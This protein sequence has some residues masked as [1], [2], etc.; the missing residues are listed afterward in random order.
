MIATQQVRQLDF[1][2]ASGLV[3]HDGRFHAVADDENDLFVFGEQGPSQRITLLPG[4]LPTEP[5]RRKAEKPDFEILAALPGLG[6]LAMGSGSRPSRER[7]VLLD[8]HG[9]TTPIDTRPLCASLRQHFS[10]LNLE[11][12]VPVADEF[13][14]MQRGN[15][16]DPRNALVF[17]AMDDLCHAMQSRQFVPRRAP[18]IVTLDLGESGGVPWSGTDLVRFDDGHL[19]ASAVLEDTADAYEDGACLGSALACF[20]T[21][22]KLRWR[23][24]LDA[25]L[26]VEG[27][28]LQGRTAWLLTDADDR[29]IASSLLRA[30]LP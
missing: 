19:L 25:R 3:L 4:D 6:L 29:R 14:L 1:S 27:I 11:G 26:K 22:G 15:R 20:T 23:R 12:A 8:A 13:V 17:L 5:A 28:A 16:S 24:P 21:D 18:R 10:Q 7:A 9:R 30:A 2:A